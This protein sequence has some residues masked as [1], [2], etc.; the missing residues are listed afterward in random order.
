MLPKDLGLQTASAGFAP[1][2][3]KIVHAAQR[4][5]ISSVGSVIPSA[6]PA[7]LAPTSRRC[8]VY[9]GLWNNNLVVI[10]FCRIKFVGLP[11]DPAF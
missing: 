7:F 3:N 5:T 1:I 2:T 8:R 11:W 4:G 6:L 10:I 9:C